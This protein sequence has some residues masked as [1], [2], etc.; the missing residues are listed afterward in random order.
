M[1]HMSDPQQ[2]L[3]MLSEAINTVSTVDASSEEEKI[4][5]MP[6]TELI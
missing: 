2:T 1:D 4:M 3:Q 6:Q 5:K